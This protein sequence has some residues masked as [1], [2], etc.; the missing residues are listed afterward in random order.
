MDYIFDKQKIESLLSDFYVSTGIA[1]TLYDASMKVVTKSPVFS[2]YCAC[3]RRSHACVLNCDTSDLLHMKEAKETGKTVFYVC[4]AGLRETITP[5]CYDGTLIAFIQTGQFRDA[6]DTCFTEHAIARIAEHYGT[7][8]DRLSALY[9]Q[10]PTISQEKRRAH[11]NIVDS[12]IKSFWLDGLITKNRSMVSVRITQYIED[13]LSDRISLPTLCE[14]FFLSKNAL[15]RLFRKEFGATVNEYI[16][17][18]RLSRAEDLLKNEP[19][20]GVSDVA[21]VCGFSDYNYFIRTFK[22]QYGVTP[23]KFRKSL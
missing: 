14:H 7:S 18:K 10:T 9:K 3:I 8:A 6:G 11:L 17:K 12:L 1:V 15:Y 21:A 2:D 16:L 4:H 19:S 13:H 23:L 20:L 5:L 22:K